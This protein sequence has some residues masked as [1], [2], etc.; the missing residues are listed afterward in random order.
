M[1]RL[2]KS[3]RKNVVPG[4]GL[5]LVLMRWARGWHEQATLAAHA[6]FHPSQVSA[7][8]RDERD[9]PVDALETTADV[10]GFPRSLLGPLLRYLRSFR[11]AARGKSR[12]AGRLAQASTAELFLVAA[13][14]LDLILEPLAAE[15][16]RRE[17]TAPEPPE[18]LLERLKRRTERQRRLLVEHVP[19][20][21]QPALVELLTRESLRLAP[22][23]PEESKEWATLATLLGKRVDFPP[24]T[25][26][27]A[28][29]TR[30]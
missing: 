26:S 11:A 24:G 7:W 18:A 12:P 27:G 20:L 21:R 22:D 25:K 1:S 9:V 19:E 2:T 17:R 13:Q 28:G 5:A 3:E 4:G 14:A 23:H 30:G 16:D 29:E 6:G 10:T 8:E 15:T